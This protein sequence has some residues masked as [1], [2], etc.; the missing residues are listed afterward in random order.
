MSYVVIIF[1]AIIAV[2]LLTFFQINTFNAVGSASCGDNPKI[3]KET[4]N[5]ADGTVTVI[6]TNMCNFCT[7]I[8]DYRSNGNIIDSTTNCK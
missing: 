1:V 6:E 8:S 7:T 5:N 3:V 4:H 2:F